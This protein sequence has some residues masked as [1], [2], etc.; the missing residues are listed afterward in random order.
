MDLTIIVVNYNVKEFLEQS[1]ISVKKSGKDIQYELFVVDNASSDGSIDLIRKKF[2][3]VQ[4]I[5]NTDNKGF[6]AFQSP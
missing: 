3:E 6:K 2:P 5:P 1:I 4:L